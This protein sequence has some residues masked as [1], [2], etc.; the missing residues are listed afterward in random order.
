MV[1]PAQDSFSAAASRLAR[2]RTYTKHTHPTATETARDIIVIFKDKFE[3]LPPHPLETYLQPKIN[4]DKQILPPKKKEVTLL[5]VFIDDFISAT[6]NTT[7]KHLS[8]LAKAI[9]HGIHSIFPPPHI[10]KHK[11]EDPISIKKL[12]Q[13]KGLFEYSKEILGWIINGQTYTLQI[14]PKKSLKIIEKLNK[15]IK[16]QSIHLKSMQKLQGKL[17]HASIGLPMGKALLSTLYKA[18]MGD[19]EYITITKNI[20]QCLKDWKTLLTEVQF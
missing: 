19:P 13:N 10:T 14:C 1:F 20:Q 12:Q 15:T 3:T 16:K 18:T 6:N 5:E 8:H 11:G 9:L 2:T 17:L 7:S 4:K